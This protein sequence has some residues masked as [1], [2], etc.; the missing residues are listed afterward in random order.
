MKG[1]L[2]IHDRLREQQDQME[3]LHVATFKSFLESNGRVGNMKMIFSS[4]GLRNDFYDVSLAQSYQFVI[5]SVVV[6]LVGLLFMTHSILLTLLMSIGMVGSFFWT[7]LIY[8]YVFGV[9]NFGLSQQLAVYIMFFMASVHALTLFGAW[10]RASD[11]PDVETRLTVAWRETNV[12]MLTTTVATSLAFF[13]FCFSSITAVVPFAL[14]CGIFSWVNYLTW[15][16]YLPTVLVVRHHFGVDGAGHAQHV[17]VAKWEWITVSGHTWTRWIVLS[18]SCMAVAALTI[19][20]VNKFTNERMQNV[21]YSRSNNYGHYDE[22]SKTNFG[23]VD[24][25][26]NTKVLLVWG[27]DK[28]LDNGCADGSAQCKQTP[29]YNEAFDLSSP[30]AQVQL[31]QFCNQLKNLDI[32]T[33]NRLMIRRQSTGQ[34]VDGVYPLELKCFIAEQDTYLRTSGVAEPIPYNFTSMQMTMQGN[35]ESYPSNVYTSASFNYPFAN[36]ATQTSCTY[37][38]SYYRHYE[39]GVL[40]FITNGGQ[41]APGSDN[42]QSYIGL[43]GGVADPS[44]QLDSAGYMTYAGEYFEIV[45]SPC[46][47]ILTSYFYMKRT[48]GRNIEL[49]AYLELRSQEK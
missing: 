41:T 29:T 44:L 18:F 12:P 4:R 32:S 38:D 24:S 25:E 13:A 33:V 6:A 20:V 22:Y 47:I 1:F 31:L 23:G 49:Q 10:V 34:T 45:I 21:M 35:N 15:G 3:A 7:N 40:D 5:G 37:C 9:Q 2:N 19:I 46:I 42:T 43:V 36:S 48:T 27:L 14:L 28:L 39:I 17:R 26:H 30:T 11:R 16:L 8:R